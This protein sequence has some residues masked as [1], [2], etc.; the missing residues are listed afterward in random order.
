MSAGGPPGAPGG[1]SGLS[2]QVKGWLG[3][4]AA[5]AT[6]ITGWIAVDN[7]WFARGKSRQC[8]MD[9]KVFTAFE[10]TPAATVSL[11]Y[12]PADGSSGFVPLTRSTADG[13]F[14]SSCEAARD[15]TT[16]SSFELLLS[17]KF[18]RG[19]LPCLHGPEH[20]GVFVDREGESTGLS[21]EV[22]GC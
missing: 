8:H 3:V 9:G 10:G 5:I 18:Q 7:D 21:V 11:G 6:L 1:G 2:S 15:A 13:S 14:S 22:R 12:A 17:G 16:G 4:G 20:T 19:P